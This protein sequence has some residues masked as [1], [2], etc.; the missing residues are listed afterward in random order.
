MCFAHSKQNTIRIL[1]SFEPDSAQS[2]LVECGECLQFERDARLSAAPR[3][4]EPAGCLQLDFS[5]NEGFRSLES[6][7]NE[8]VGESSLLFSNYRPSKLLVG[9]NFSSLGDSSNEPP[10][11]R[12]QQ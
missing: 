4:S 8:T 3:V 2:M 11:S 7:F 9:Y 5:R 6:N 10:Y 1:R 12:T